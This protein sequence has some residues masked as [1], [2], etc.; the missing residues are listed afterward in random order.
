MQD[1]PYYAARV[2]HETSVKSRQIACSTVVAVAVAVMLVVVV[3]VV[4]VVVVVVVLAGIR[5]C[6]LRI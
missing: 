1:S 6:A 4:N 2:A 5:I 3:N